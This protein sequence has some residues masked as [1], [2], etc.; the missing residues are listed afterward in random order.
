MRIVEPATWW[1]HQ[2]QQVLP[3]LGSV[4][5]SVRLSSTNS[6]KKERLLVK[7]ILQHL[8]K[9]DKEKWGHQTVKCSVSSLLL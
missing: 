5:Y 4:A 8:L 6:L 9:N 1:I 2:L 3:E 7:E